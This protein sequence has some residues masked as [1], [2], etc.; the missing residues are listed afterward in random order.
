M[1]KRCLVVIYSILTLLSVAVSA[2]SCAEMTEESSASTTAAASEVT[3]ELTDAEIRKA[4]HD[5]LPDVDYAGKQFRI[6]TRN[7]CTNA[8]IDDIIMEEM[9][10]D[11]ID[12][13]VFTRNQS[14]EERF[15]TKITVIPVDEADEATLTN[16]LRKSITAG[17]DEYDLAVGHMIHMGTSATNGL[18]YNWYDIPYI[19]FSKPWWIHSAEEQLAIYGKTFFALGDLTNNALDYTY[20]YY[21]NKNLYTD[22]NLAFPYQN[23]RDGTW[24]FDYATSLVKNLYSD[25][26]ND[27]K[28]DEDDLYGLVTNCYSGSVTWTYAFGEFITKKNADGYPE[29]VLN[30]EKTIKI[31]EKLYDL[32]FGSEGVYV[33]PNT[34]SPSGMAWHEATIKL[35]NESRAILASGLFVSAIKDFREIEDDY[36]FLPY[37]KWDEAQSGYYTMIDGH[38]PLF[39]IPL[40][41]NNP[42][43]VGIITEAMSA[44]GY[45]II[46]PAYYDVALKTKFT[47]DEESAEMIDLILAGRV[48][49]FGYLYDGWNGMAFYLQNLLGFNTQTKDFSSFYAKKEK[50]VVKY[51]DKILKAYDEYGQ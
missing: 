38:G 3:A 30:N 49:D 27:G 41:I 32:Y 20:C 5:D 15:N 22:Y 1:L 16:M 23:V 51:Y 29:L 10:G 36:G 34:T 6:I 44:E 12:D 9:T 39:A 8:H 35:F 48:F 37:P 18:Y 24:T 14:V 26:N 42:E 46:T 43:F 19:N 47:R 25:L 7:G 31:V 33:T 50:A 13:A 11:V 17:S 21:F 2:F 45:K 28:H 40:T 4:I